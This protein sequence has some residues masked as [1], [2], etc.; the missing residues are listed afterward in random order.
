MSQDT[1]SRCRLPDDVMAPFDESIQGTPWATYLYA[2]LVEGRNYEEPEVQE[3]G[4]KAME[5]GTLPLKTPPAGKWP[6]THKERILFLESIRHDPFFAPSFNE[7]N[8]AIEWHRTFPEEDLCSN[9]VVIFQ[10]GRKVDTWDW[11]EPTYWQ[12]GTAYAL[13]NSATGPAGNPGFQQ[14]LV[15]QPQ[16]ISNPTPSALYTKTGSSMFQ[17]TKNHGPRKDYYS[18]SRVRLPLIYNAD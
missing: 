4:R 6:A 5:W 15:Y 3:L 12:E 13:I 9:E 17:V 1:S 18:C 7:I 2:T 8:A 14:R 10:K 11:K 16:R